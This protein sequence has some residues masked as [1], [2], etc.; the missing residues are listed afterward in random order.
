MVIAVKIIRAAMTAAIAKRVI[1]SSLCLFTVASVF[2]RGTSPQP[3]LVGAS[4][5]QP[6]GPVRLLVAEQRQADLL[7]VVLAS[8]SA[9]RLALSYDGGP[10]RQDARADQRHRYGQAMI[11][12][13]DC[14]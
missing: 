1:M 13:G 5:P 6:E 4:G 12:I 14:W 8:D 2:C 3:I 11:R 10:I 9:V 7:E